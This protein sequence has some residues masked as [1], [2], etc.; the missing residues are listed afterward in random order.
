M[1][2]KNFFKRTF[3]L[4]NLHIQK[5]HSV[6]MQTTHVEDLKPQIY[7]TKLQVQKNLN[8]SCFIKVS[9]FFSEAKNAKGIC[10]V[11]IILDL[12]YWPVVEFCWLEW[13]QS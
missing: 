4:V 6:I 11:I 1:S 13:A 3:T 9:F 7:K 12:N 10:F 2:G 5:L 8:F